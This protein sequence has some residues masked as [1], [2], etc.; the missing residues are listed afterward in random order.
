MLFSHI[1]IQYGCI[2]YTL[3]LLYIFHYK[4]EPELVVALRSRIGI[5]IGLHLQLCPR[6]KGVVHKALRDPR[7]VRMAARSTTGCNPVYIAYKLAEKKAHTASAART[8]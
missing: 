5:G 7:F 1:Y 2:I 8:A 4:V 3:E 6:S